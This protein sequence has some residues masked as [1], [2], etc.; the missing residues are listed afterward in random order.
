MLQLV[1]T[2]MSATAVQSSGRINGMAAM[3]A[4]SGAGW[5][6][7]GFIIIANDMVIGWCRSWWLVIHSDTIHHGLCMIKS[8]QNLRH[9]KKKLLYLHE[10][11]DRQQT[12]ADIICYASE[13]RRRIWENSSNKKHMCFLNSS[14]SQEL[15]METDVWPLLIRSFPNNMYIMC[16]TTLRNRVPDHPPDEKPIFEALQRVRMKWKILH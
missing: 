4:T 12:S 15:G 13:R 16:W 7:A 3:W 8:A 5:W 11:S 2:W 6:V 14:A 1:M 9:L 10:L